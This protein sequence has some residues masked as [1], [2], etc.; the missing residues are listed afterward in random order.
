M[1]QLIDSTIPLEELQGRFGEEAV[2]VYNAIRVRP[3][4]SETKGRAD[5]QG[6]DHS[7]VTPRL[8][9]KSML[10][11]KNTR[12]PVTTPEPGVQWHGLVAGELLVR[13]SE[14]R[15]IAPGLGH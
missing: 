12:P 1:L 2:W 14:A 13:L 15:E 3:L 7:E 5:N 9:T 6:I 10:A 11:S 4:L 8:A